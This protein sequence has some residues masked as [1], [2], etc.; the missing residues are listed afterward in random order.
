MSSKSLTL[1]YRTKAFHMFIIT[2]LT[3]FIFTLLHLYDV[4]FMI[5]SDETIYIKAGLAYLNGVM[6]YNFNFEHPPLAKYIIGFFS[7]LNMGFLL[8]SI[9]LSL[10]IIVA[11]YIIYRYLN[12]ARAFLYV[13]L[14]TTD[15]LIIN[16]SFFNLLDNIVLPLLVLFMYITLSH[17]T[18]KRYH[19]LDSAKNT[20]IILGILAG[21]ALASKWSSIYVM[22]PMFIILCLL[23]KKI[24]KNIPLFIIMTIISYTLP[25][26]MDFIRGGPYLFI[27]HNVDMVKYMI[28]RHSI[29]LPLMINGFLTLVGKISFW[30]HQYHEYLTL[31]IINST[32]INYTVFM[33]KVGNLLMEFNFWLGSFAWPLM[34]Y[35]SLKL[36]YDSAKKK[37][38]IWTL[39]SS[40]IIGSILLPIFHGN[41]AWYY[42]FYAILA[43]FAMIK[44]APKKLLV[45]AIGLNVAQIIL[46]KSGVLNAT[47]SFS[48]SIS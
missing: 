33:T 21:L 44:Y 25:F 30:L 43:P 28:W 39:I 35:Y 10:T 29:T 2:L 1:F 27:I 36:T 19:N 24:M 32:N 5:F 12:Y 42:V 26:T 48:F 11:S 34:F 38:H 31:T 13:I 40:A 45:L 41:I 18:F 4:V 3:F 8:P 46:L 16:M 15:T 6:P 20:C 37:D 23:D 14:V 47:Y 7:I 17:I 9:A 22:M